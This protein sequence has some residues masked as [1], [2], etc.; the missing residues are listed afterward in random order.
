MI[1]HQRLVII[2]KVPEKYFWGRIGSELGLCERA[3]ERVGAGGVV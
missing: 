3:D 2:C 1:V